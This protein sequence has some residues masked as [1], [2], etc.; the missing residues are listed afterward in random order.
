[1]TEQSR[2]A[3]I[4]FVVAH[5]VLVS[6]AGAAVIL[7]G[8]VA[9]GRGTIV[10]IASIAVVCGVVLRPAGLRAFGSGIVGIAARVAC[11]GIGVIVA[12]AII[13]SAHL[14]ADLLLSTTAAAVVLALVLDQFAAAFDPI[15]NGYGASLGTLTVVGVA[16]TIPLWLGPAID[17]PSAPPFLA[18]GVV[19]A[20]PL[21]CLSAVAG[22]DYLRSAWFYAHTPLG[23]LRYSLPDPF[24]TTLAYGVLGTVLWIAAKWRG[25]PMLRSTTRNH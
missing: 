4:A 10:T 24:T 2:G 18:D 19:W 11:V 1:M 9:L 16:S 8:P 14:P 6:A 3:G 5:L 15:G 17:T 22:Y 12:I 20:S 21:S 13:G 25:T 7:S 23:G